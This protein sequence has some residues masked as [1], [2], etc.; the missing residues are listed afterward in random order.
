[1]TDQ[2]TT[3]QIDFNF[4]VQNLYREESFTDLKAGAIRR[5]VPVK[6]DGSTDGARTEIF[7]GT[8][9]LLT[10]EGPLPVQAR[11]PANNFKEA[12]ETFPGAMRQA[13]QEMIQQLQEMQQ[14]M[15]EKEDSRI[16][17]PGQ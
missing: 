10:P 14:K 8:A 2:T 15:K 13:T 4:D 6:T 7:I 12:L 17:V 5:L 9:Q 1:M 3:D 11:L 16:I